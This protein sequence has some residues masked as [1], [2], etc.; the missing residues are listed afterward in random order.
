[1]LWI[2]G[3]L[4]LAAVSIADLDDKHVNSEQITDREN[5]NSEQQELE[6]GERVEYKEPFHRASPGSIPGSSIGCLRTVCKVYAKVR[7]ELA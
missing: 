1:M 2:A 4:V 5:A 7:N 6:A 3:D